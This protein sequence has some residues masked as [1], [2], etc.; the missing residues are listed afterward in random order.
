MRFDREGQNYSMTVSVCSTRQGAITMTGTDGRLG[1]KLAI[2]R[3]A[4]A[5]GCEESFG[6]SRHGTA[7]SEGRRRL[8]VMFIQV[9]IGFPSGIA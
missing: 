3:E 5:A 9:W 8:V 1:E 4:P 6:R 7:E 2:W